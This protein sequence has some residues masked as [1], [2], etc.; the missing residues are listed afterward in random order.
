MQASGGVVW[1]ENRLKKRERK[2]E[3]GCVMTYDLVTWSMGEVPE[4][5]LWKTFSNSA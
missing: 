2:D 4:H 5:D 1:T 3:Q